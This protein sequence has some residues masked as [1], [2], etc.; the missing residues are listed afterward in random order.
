MRIEYF[1]ELSQYKI[2]CG[3]SCAV[4][5]GRNVRGNFKFDL[6]ETDEHEC[7]VNVLHHKLK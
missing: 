6:C 5:D 2:H 1:A 3:S 4:N 7:K